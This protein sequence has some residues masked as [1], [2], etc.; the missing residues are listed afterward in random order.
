[1]KTIDEANLIDD[2]LM[3][4]VASDPDVG[5]EFCRTLLSVLLQ[6]EIG[7]VRVLAQRV[8][9]GLD[10]RMRGVRLDVEVTEE[11]KDNTTRTA[12]VYDIEPH[13]RRDPDM[14]RMMRFRQAK[15]DSRYMKSGDNDFS[16]LPD[17]YMIQITNFDP[18]DK[19]YML[20]T[21]HNKCDEVNDLK[22]DD[23]LKFL[24]FYTKGRKG[25]S[26]AIQNML[27]YLQN[28]REAAAVDS[29]TKE[30]DKLLNNV[31]QNPEIR[32]KYMTFGE[33]LDRTYIEGREEGRE[34]GL[35]EGQDKLL[36]NLICRN[37]SQG[38]SV[39]EMANFI[40]I[41]EETITRICRLAEKYAPEY[42]TEAI[43]DELQK[44]KKM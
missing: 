37:L 42:D 14:F 12:N 43:F 39:T 36:I 30:V 24:Y 31:R 13:T 35:K 21:I 16:H 44:I 25:G 29:A 38:M 40:G 32:G 34:E 20:Y 8:I 22:C 41:E 27:E 4:L 33:K 28:S 3:N 7:S 6:K 26:K 2:V 15:I 17:L 23:G 1:M 9:P 19:D 11:D 18:F 5:E 10:E